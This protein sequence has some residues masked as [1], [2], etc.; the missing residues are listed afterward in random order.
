MGLQKKSSA[1][2]HLEQALL[3]MV[4]L[5]QARAAR[6]RLVAFVDVDEGPPS[7]DPQGGSLPLV[8]GSLPHLGRQ[9]FARTSTA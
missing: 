7:G 4:G 5:V 8:G 6:Y 2:P 3:N 1:L 9:P